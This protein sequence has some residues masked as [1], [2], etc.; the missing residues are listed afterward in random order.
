MSYEQQKQSYYNF[1]IPESK[2]IV[3]DTFKCLTKIDFRK[4][5]VPLLFTSGGNDRL[6]PALLNHRN[7]VRYTA[8]NSIADYIEFRDHAHLIFGQLAWKEEADFILN[9]LQRIE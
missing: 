5:H 1:A 8:G 3:R 6:I 7:Y 9:W 4:S 2:R